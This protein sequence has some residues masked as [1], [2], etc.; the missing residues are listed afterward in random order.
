MFRIVRINSS[1]IFTKNTIIN[2]S[3]FIEIPSN[4]NDKHKEKS[5]PKKLNTE[6]VKKEAE[7]KSI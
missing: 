7:K 3:K 2:A 6:A 5:K 4:D 1:M